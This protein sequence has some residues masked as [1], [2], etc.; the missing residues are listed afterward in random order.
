M[1][2]VII[3]AIAV[4]CSVGAMTGVLLVF[5]QVENSEIQKQNE[6]L[7]E[8]YRDLDLGGMYREE[9]LA[10]SSNKCITINPLS[11]SLVNAYL[12]LQELERISEYTIRKQSTVEN[13]E[14]KMELLHEKYPN[15]DF[16]VLEKANC[17]YEKEWNDFLHYLAINNPDM[18]P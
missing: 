10:I 3:I 11:A 2:P 12:G 9:Y 5:Q 16:F 1:K 7:Q 4:V 17:P 18:L 14:Q 13:L 8:Y 15:T 6:E